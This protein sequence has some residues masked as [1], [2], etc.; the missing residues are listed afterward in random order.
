MVDTSVISS[1]QEQIDN[2]SYIESQHNVILAA[3]S[4]LQE[5]LEECQPDAY[6]QI[7]IE[8]KEGWNMI[9]Y[10]LIFSTNVAE[11]IS[12]LES[13][14]KLL[15]DNNGKFYWP[16][17]GYNSIGNFI[18]GHGYFIKMNTDRDFIFEP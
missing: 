2:L 14:V 13:D 4:V 9:G 6:G 17:F 3:N 5:L 8:L 12:D 11:K 16:G 18:P 15:K 1:L 7:T 10:N